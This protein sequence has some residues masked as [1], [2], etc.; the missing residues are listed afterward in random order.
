MLHLLAGLFRSHGVAIEEHNDHLILADRNGERVV[1]MARIFEINQHGAVHVVQF[2]VRLILANDQMIVESAGGIGEGAEAAAHEAFKG[3]ANNSFHVLLVALLKPDA[4]DSQV[5]RH[6]WE[7][8][9]QTFAVTSGPVTAR[10]PLPKLPKKTG[11]W[12]TVLRNAVCAQPLTGGT[13]WLR[14]YVARSND[15]PP[16]VEVLL[17]NVSWPAVI[18]QMA[19]LPWPVADDFYSVRWFL[20]L[21]NDV[22][23]V[24]L[25]VRA[26]LAGGGKR[27]EPAVLADLHA[28][29]MSE[30]LAQ[31]AVDFMPVAFGRELLR[32]IGINF[33]EHVDIVDS[34][35]GERVTVNL[36][37]EPVW[38]HVVRMA[39][40]A[41]RGGTMAGDDFN[42]IALRSAEVGA[43]DQFLNQGGKPEEAT[44]AL[45]F[46]WPHAWV[47]KPR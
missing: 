47:R 44:L 11:D 41:R 5:E 28:Q 15:Q 38:C 17:D 10:G 12:T 7:C 3:F 13:H 1:A 23:D 24:Q 43:I 14:L 18:E 16:T 6:T 30:Q 37:D 42:A 9:D 35:S 36:A 21:Q 26:F 19:A 46:A 39:E 25:V 33:V 45:A 32:D 31:Q 27:D 2:D 40:S 8:G 20:L 34:T 22:P 29:G 4:D